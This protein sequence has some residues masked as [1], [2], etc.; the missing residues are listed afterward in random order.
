[1]NIKDPVE[2]RGII[3]YELQRKLYD[4]VTNIKFPWFYMEDTTYERPDKSSYNTP[5]FG[6]LLLSNDGSRSEYL[7]LFTP[8]LTNLQEKFEFKITNVIRMRLGFLMK[9]R[10]NFPGDSYVYNKPH[11]D[12]DVPHLTAIYYLNST[13]GDTVIFSDTQP[14][15]RYREWKRYL[16]EQGKLVLFDGKYYHASTCPKM[17]PTRIALTINFNIEE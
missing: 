10:Y 16:P 3:D 12:A 7:D 1:M 13:D 14:S 6:H 9:T 15:E 11:V 8:I 2:V 17:F 4:T 5:A